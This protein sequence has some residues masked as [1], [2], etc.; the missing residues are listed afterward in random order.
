MYIYIYT[1]VFITININKQTNKQLQAK[2]RQAAASA[3]LRPR[4]RLRLRQDLPG[5][6]QG[7]VRKHKNDINI[8][9]TKHT[10]KQDKQEVANTYR[11]VQGA[12]RP[13]AE[14]GA[15]GTRAGGPLGEGDP[16]HGGQ[17]AES[18]NTTTTTTT[19]TN[20]N[21]NDNN[22]NDN[23][24]DNDNNTVNNIRTSHEF[25]EYMTLSAARD[26]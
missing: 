19:T 9:T 8:Q 4:Q 2:A 21:N 16:R 25:E 5:R 7:A 11:Q 17:G 20:N 14:A 24:N 10:K 18:R 23:S 13:V 26:R 6:V 12:V 3:A 22:N 15:E 1:H